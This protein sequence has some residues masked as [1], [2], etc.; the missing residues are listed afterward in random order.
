MPYR[1]I[2]TI[3]TIYIIYTTYN[4][5]IG[6]Q[7]RHISAPEQRKRGLEQCQLKYLGRHKVG[8]AKS[9]VACTA[10]SSG[11]RGEMPTNEKFV[12][13]R[14]TFV[15]IIEEVKDRMRRAGTQKNYV[16]AQYYCTLKEV[17]CQ[18]KT[19]QT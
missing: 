9:H 6:W 4:R 11:V 1:P 10:T 2:Y 16:L 19:A 12:L 5:E 7:G 13:T 3:Y 8:T 17:L 18:G 14:E 15:I